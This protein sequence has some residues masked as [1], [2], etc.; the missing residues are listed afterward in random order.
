MK[1]T[2][3]GNRQ[4]NFVDK[5]IRWW[6]SNFKD[7]FN[8]AWRDSYSHSELLFSDGVMFSASQYNNSTR[9]T[10]KNPKSIAWVD[11]EV[12]ITWEQEKLVRKFCQ[13]QDGKK[14]D[15]LGVLGFVIGNSDAPN[16]WFC[17]EVCVRALQE[18]GLFEG[19]TPSKVSPNQLYNLL[20]EKK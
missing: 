2:F 17:S 13:K 10:N 15:Y 16:R 5:A 6:T 11:V 9:F 18:A 19:V 1:V 12:G 7:K 4:G 8:G 14:Y 20:K 3:Y